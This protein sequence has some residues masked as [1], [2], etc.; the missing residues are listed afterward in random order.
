MLKEVLIEQE[1]LSKEKS[2]ENVEHLLKDSYG[3]A[4]NSENN[5]KNDT[6]SLSICSKSARYSPKIQ[7][8]PAKYFH[9]VLTSRISLENSQITRD[10]SKILLRIC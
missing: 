3:I 1:K 7:G 10:F 8:I 2:Q 6:F 9:T 4:K 5:S